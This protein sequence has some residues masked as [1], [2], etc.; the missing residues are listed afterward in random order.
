MVRNR[1]RLAIAV[2]ALAFAVAVGVTT[3]RNFS[4]G[5]DRAAARSDDQAFG[6][7]RSTAAA[8]PV[9]LER[10]DGTPLTLAELK[11]QVLFVNFWATWCPPCVEEMPSM[12]E[13]GRELTSKYPN[14]FRMVAVSVDEGWPQVVQFFR[15]RLP[16]EALVARDHDMVA[17]RAYYCT[18]RGACPESFKFPET[19]IVDA[20]GR[21]VAY[22][23]GPR[24]WSHPAARR[25]IERIIEG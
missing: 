15:G 13:L 7:D 6:V 1:K 24:D 20:A 23:V 25:V 4:Q 2:A 16:P 11:G 3:V 14:R 5:S 12:L 17:T 10:P 18:A 9:T 22:M 21:V 8:P 19:Y